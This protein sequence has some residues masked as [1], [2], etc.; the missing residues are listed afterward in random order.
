MV[1]RFSTWVAFGALLTLPVTAA[2]QNIDLANGADQIWRGATECAAAGAFLDRADVANGDDRADLIIGAP[3]TTGCAST[4]AGSVYIIP[5]GP[6]YTG[7]HTLDTAPI[8]IA[9]ASAN[10][11]FGAAIAAG[12][13]LNNAGTRDLVVAAPDAASGRGVVYVFRGP[14]PN[15]AHLTV[16]DAVLT[17]TGRPG[18][19]LGASLAT[20]DLDNDGYREIIMGAPGNN[21]VLLLYGRD[22][23][24]GARDL[25]V[26][27]P[28][29]TI[30]GGA[31]IGTVVTA[32]AVTD[33]AIYDLGIGDPTANASTGAA[34]MF[35]GHNG[36]RL[37]GSIDPTTAAD[38]VLRGK[39][40]GDRFGSS[41]RTADFDGDRQRDLL[42][43]APGG[44]GRGRADSGEAFLLW[45]PLTRSTT[46]SSPGVAIYGSF[47]G[48]ATSEQVDMGDINRDT[49][50]DLMLLAPG[51]NSGKGMVQILYG[52]SKAQMGSEFDIA[53]GF[54]RA[55]WGPTS[56][57]SLK[58]MVSYEVTGEGARDIVA[59]FPDVNSSAGTKAGAVYVALSPK[60]VLN[61]TSV[62]MTATTGGG[63]FGSVQV[64]N[65]GTGVLNWSVRKLGG[66]AW[67]SLSVSSGQS[68]NGYPQSVTLSASA[69]GLPAGTYTETV[70]VQ[71]ESPDL[72]M[73]L[74]I[75]VTFTVSAPTPAPNS[76]IPRVVFGLGDYMAYQGGWLLTYTGA[77]SG[78][79]PDKWLRTA[80]DAY[81]TTGG[82]VKLATG[83][84]DG[85]GLDE[86]VV[87]LGPAAHG[88]IDIFDD[89]D[90]NYALIRTLYLGWDD[91]SQYYGVMYPAVGDIDGDG[92]AEIV[93]GLGPNGGGWV[94]L[95]DDAA[96]SFADIAWIQ[97]T[98]AG[99]N[100]SNG[101]TH[102]AVGDLDGDGQAEIV[103]GL[104]A[105]SQGW[106]EIRNS[107]SGNYAS[108]IWIQ[109]SWSY[110][111]NLSGG[112]VTWPAVGDL[113]ND[114]RAEIVLGFG[115]GSQGWLE[116]RDDAASNY[117]SLKWIQLDA[118]DYNSANGETHP[119]VG[120]IDGV[121]GAE[122]A[123]GLGQWSGAGGRVEIRSGTATDY[124]P[125]Q[126]IQSGWT[127]YDSSGGPVF[128]AV[129]KL[130]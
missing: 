2:A 67:L 48:Y 46:L 26:N 84:V 72:V 98:W 81:N 100:S 55:V 121:A 47:A 22:T 119:A 103:L 7:E 123:I 83:D 63:S 85:D 23:L 96:A 109:G 122:I 33:D 113:D 112:G 42:V 11:R 38:L 12:N 4:P 104:G 31:A 80:N 34:Y 88:E 19:H 71:S 69:A 49:P 92:R 99:Y 24:S 108:K 37:A 101:E 58:A 59:A 1:I 95:I 14:L 105:G 30:H 29:A 93:V 44:D 64:T 15:T 77:D 61:A 41:L 74:D 115:R 73:S 97:G 111:D 90:H 70:R 51:A 57:G 17:I 5:G 27:G 89:A 102:P 40:T 35:Y 65:P 20:G 13:V 126:W 16:A 28:D 45:G 50:N 107:A 18:D 106:V 56:N 39:A 66:A 8:V 3:G 32:G 53:N 68:S 128:P 91:Y 87:C 120:D 129:G 79:A 117:A 116:I 9:G 86:I 52:R 82:G 78:Y 6:T 54:D 127:G 43:A 76:A 21:S 60:L 118:V 114:G 124:M 10:G 62:T 25:A 110:Y 75:P 130:R 36:T 94:K 125:L